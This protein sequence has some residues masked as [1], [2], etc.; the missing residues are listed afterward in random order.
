MN[1]ILKQP[2]YFAIHTIYQ[3]SMLRFVQ[4]LD[5]YT[6][7]S[8]DSIFIHSCLHNHKNKPCQI[9]LQFKYKLFSATNHNAAQF[10]AVVLRF[11]G[12]TEGNKMVLT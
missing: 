2:Y 7:I 9:L 11:A 3:L 4:K 8:N 6:E 10:Q 1:E 5:T 12:K